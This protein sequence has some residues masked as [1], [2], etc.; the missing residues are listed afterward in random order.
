MYE[1]IGS[2]LPVDKYATAMQ[3][4]EQNGPEDELSIASF[5][6]SPSVVLHR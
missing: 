3:A 2:C 4:V 6:G 1:I 5:L